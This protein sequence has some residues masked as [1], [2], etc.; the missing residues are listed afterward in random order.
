MEGMSVLTFKLCS[1]GII[2]IISLVG[3]FLP[4]KLR[5]VSAEKRVS[6]ALVS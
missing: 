5:S 6:F 1:V 3:S 4:L 2:L